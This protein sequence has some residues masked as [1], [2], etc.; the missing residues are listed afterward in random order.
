M[1]LRIIVPL[2]VACGL[3]METMDA[4][5]LSTSLP[6]IAADL[7]EDPI[8]LKLAVTSYLLS[9]AVFIPI[10]GWVADKFGARNVFMGAILVFTTGSVLC[11]MSSSL[12]EFVVWRIV[13]G[14]G[15]AMMVPVGRLVILR[16]IPKNELI[17]GM[18]WLTVPALIAPVIGPILGGFLT[19][20][21]NWR[22]I[23]YINVP[24]GILGLALTWRYIANF[25]EPKVFELDRVGFVLTGV[26]LSAFVFGLALI[27]SHDRSNGIGVILALIGILVCAIYVWH[28]RRVSHPVVELR[29]LRIPTFRASIIGGSAFRLGMG[30]FY[31]LLPLMLQLS[32]G[33]SAFQSGLIT[34]ASAA[35]ALAMKTTAPIILRRFGFKRVLVWN[36]VIG[37][38]FLFANALFTPDTP[39][40]VMIA[41]LLAGGFFRSLEFTAVNAIAYADIRAHEMSSATSFASVAQQISLSLGVAIG[42][43]VLEASRAANAEL[44]L[45]LNDFVLAFCVIG[46]IT[47]LSALSFLRLP[48]NAGAEISGAHVEAEVAKAA[49]ANPRAEASTHQ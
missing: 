28:A 17:R 12:T 32:F 3:F 34:F 40:V 13:Q 20:Y 4:T 6:V 33:L 19:T 42:A 37:G 8:R 45:S 18:A 16:T 36:A 31:F 15:G 48:A 5:V 7:G 1:S 2:T 24:I 29:L 49:A 11:G 23:F 10:S 41:I 39:H 21:A 46:A 35:G 22:W 9:L 25:R 47:S 27:G 26:G 38:G 43:L 44:V 14:I 30:A